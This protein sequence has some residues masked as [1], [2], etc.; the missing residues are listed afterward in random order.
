MAASQASPHFCILFDW[1]STLAFSGRRQ[2]F[3]QGKCSAEAPC[4]QH[5]ARLVLAALKRGQLGVGIVSNTHTSEE[6]MWAGLDHLGLRE[7]V[8]FIHVAPSGSECAKPAPCA[9]LTAKAKAEEKWGKRFFYCPRRFVFVG[10]Q[11]TEDIEGP[12]RVGMHTAWIPPVDRRGEFFPREDTPFVL[13]KRKPPVIVLRNLLA[14]LPLLVH[15]RI[16][17][18]G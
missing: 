10:N 16:L 8:D 17:V 9:Y 13:L 14:L 2:A 11:W 5:D 3:I 12:R 4:L 6:E 15:E 18:R 7:Y 1:G